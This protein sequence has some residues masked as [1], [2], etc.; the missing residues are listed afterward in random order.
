MDRRDS[1]GGSAPSAASPDP[2]SP[3][4]R[5]GNPHAG[6]PS[7]V[8]AF[9]ERAGPAEVVREHVVAPPTVSLPK[10]GGSV[11]GMGEQFQANPATGSAGLS[12]PLGL[13]PGR[14]GITPQLSLSYDS[15]G[16]NGPFGMGW[17]LSVPAVSR[18]TSRGI[19]RYH[20]GRGRWPDESDTFQLSDSEASGGEDLVPA[21]DDPIVRTVVD[22][23][24]TW[25]VHRYRPRVESGF[26]RIERFSL[27][28]S[29]E[30]YW[31]TIS[32]SNVVRTYGKAASARVVDPND[33][34]RIFEWLLEEERDERGHVVVYEYK[35]EDRAGVG[36]GLSE[37]HRGDNPVAWTYLKRVRYG[38][39]APGST[40]SFRFVLVLD[41]GEHDPDDPGVDDDTATGAP[42]WTLRQDPF[43]THRARFERR[44]YRLCQRVLM[45][46]HFTEL[47][48]D[49][50]PVRS[51]ELTYDE[52]PRATTLSSAL[53]RGWMPNGSGGW[54]TQTLPPLELSYTSAAI[55]ETL[56]F[57]DGLDDLPQ[58]LDTSQ[59]QWVDL[60]GEGLTGLLGQWG[61]AWW[62]QRNEG[63]ATLGPRVRLS[64]RPNVDLGASG[65]RL[66]DLGGDGKLDVV[67]M[68]GPL[69]GYL[70]RDADRNDWK[71]RRPL[72]DLPNIDIE[73]PNV[74]SIDLTGDGL[75]DLLITEDTV[76]P[77]GGAM[78]WY[79]S[80][81]KDGYAEGKRSFV[82]RDLDRGPRVLFSAGN[83]IIFLADMTGDGLADIVRV[84]HNAVDYWPNQGY[85]SF[86]VRVQMQGAP[87]LDRRERFDPKRVRLADI[88]GTGPTDLLYIGP[89]HVR[90]W[91][92]RSGNGFDDAIELSKLKGVSSADD[93]QLADINGD[94]TQAL[95]WS[96]PLFSRR[97]QPLRYLSLMAEGQPYL[98]KAVKNNL[99]RETRLSYT[100]ST[101]F[102][103]ADRK[104]GTPWA[105]RLPFPVQCL[106][107]VEVLDH[108]PGWR[109]TNTY[110]Y[111]HGYF[112]GHEREF[113]G[114]GMVEQ[115]DTESFSD[116]E[117]ASN[118]DLAH[119]AAPVVT[120][121][122]L[123]TGAWPDGSALEDAFAS[124][125]ADLGSGAH[126]PRKNVLPEGL[127]PSQRRDAAR[128]LRGKPLR[129]EVY[130]DDGTADAN[131][132]YSVVAH[133][134][135]VRSLED[136]RKFDLP[137][138][139]PRTSPGITQVVPRESVTWHTERDLTDPRVAHS[140]VL[141]V[142]AYGTVLRQAEVVYPRRGSG[143]DAE[144]SQGKVVV[145]AHTVIDDDTTNDRLHLAVPSTEETWE[146]TG[147]T[148]SEASAPTVASLNT[149]FDGASVIAFHT[150]PSTGDQKRRLSRLE[151]RYW[152]NDLSNTLALGTLG[153]R[154]LVHSKRL[155]A[156]SD[157]LV[158]DRFG[159]KVTGTH[160]TA[161]GYEEETGT[162]IAG[163]YLP[164]GVSTL[165]SS[166]F[167]RPS[168][169]V[170]PFG[171]T[172]TLTYDSHDLFVTEVADPLSNTVVA[173]HDYRVLQPWKVTDP[174]GNRVE[175]AFDAM[176]R[177]TAQATIGKGTSEGDSLS[178]PTQRWTYEP[179]RWYEANGPAR[180]KHE[181]R[182]EH[183]G[184]ADW[185]VT[186]AYSDGSGRVVQLK[187]QAAPG[188]APEIVSGS[189]VWSSADPRWVGSGRT[190]VDNKGRVVKQYEPF[191]SHTEAFEDEDELVQWGV[192]PVY[193]YD[194]IGRMVGT[195]LPDGSW[196][197]VEPGAWDTVTWDECD[198]ID[199]SDTT[200]PGYAHRN[201]PTTA[202]LDVLGRPYQVEQKLDG[203]TTLTTHVA[204]DIQG[205]PATLTDP[206]S[207]AIHIQKGDCLGRG[208]YEDSADA[209]ETWTL[210][211]VGGQPVRQWKSGDLSQRW[212][213]D[214]LRRLV[215]HHA[216][217][218]AGGTERLVQLTIYGEILD[219]SY[220]ADNLR[221]RPWR[222]YDTAGVQTTGSFDFKGNPL[223][224][225]RQVLHH[226]LLESMAGANWSSLVPLPM[227]G[228]NLDVTTLES[229]ASSALSSE[230]FTASQ[231][232]DALGR[233]VTKTS[234]D[235]SVVSHTYDEGA[236]LVAISGDLAY[237]SATTDFVTD[238]E[239]NPRGQRTRVVY[240]NDTATT[241]TYDDNRFWP[242]RILTERTSDSP[243]TKLQDLALSYDPVGNVVGITDS[244]QQ[245]VFFANTQVGPNQDFTYD[246]LYRLVSATGREKDALPQPGPGSPT[247]GGLPAGGAA[248]TVL[249]RYTEEYTYDDAGNLTEMKHIRGG[250]TA[251]RRGY[252]VDT[253]SNRLLKS[254]L[255]GDDPDDP[256][257][258]S[259]AYTWSSR[260]TLVRIPHL[261]AG[262]DNLLPDFRDQVRKAELDSLG[263]VA[264]YLYDADRKRVMKRVRQGQNIFDRIYVGEWEVWRHTTGSGLQQERE[265]LHVMDGDKRLCM[266]ETLTWTGGS[267]VGTPVSRYRF[268]LG[269]HLDSALLEVNDAGEVITYEEY[270]PYG[271]TAWW[272]EK[273]GIQVS[274]KR[275]R[276][277]GME[278][279]EETGLSYHH[280]RYYM[281]WLGRWGS[282]DPAGLVD[283]GNRFGYCRGSP[284]GRVD[285]IGLNSTAQNAE[286][287]KDHDSAATEQS[288]GFPDAAGARILP[289]WAIP[290]DR[291]F[292]WTVGRIDPI[293]QLIGLQ[294]A[295]QSAVLTP[296]QHALAIGER[297]D[298]IQQSPYISMSR[299]E[300]GAPAFTGR[301]EG[302]V[303]DLEAVRASGRR[304]VDQGELA[305]S[306]KSATSLSGEPVH[307]DRIAN[308]EAGQNQPVFVDGQNVGNEREVL[309]AGEAPAS[310]VGRQRIYGAAKRGSQVLGAIGTV[311]TAI[312]LGAA[313]QA[314]YD[315]ESARPIVEELVRQGGAWAGS[316]LGA[317]AGGAF[318]SALA[319]ATAPKL[320][321]TLAVGALEGRMIGAVVGGAIG[322]IAG[323]E[324]A[325]ALILN[326]DIQ[327]RH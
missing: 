294:A 83:E 261:K 233:I 49:P 142:D 124:E 187:A 299:T 94:G 219:S 104:A 102:Y 268:Q 11:Q 87:L 305:A 202:R 178:D 253:A 204:L 64:Q 74:R 101:A 56:A 311:D 1:R 171:E 256:G 86:G 84:R 2:H 192:T 210:L 322:G 249:A 146:L 96:S 88:D 286:P 121:T 7:T 205:F 326:F 252:D 327:A 45:F 21:M 216:T 33:S 182:K 149:A 72:R 237:E 213:Y 222:S 150:A 117:G 123:H 240:G 195:D 280:H 235:G 119:H 282:A 293:P 99:G 26:A 218:G 170:D 169:V 107:K 167:Y 255:P 173:V 36:T 190:V 48:T 90:M 258:F 197:K 6:A 287:T 133:T 265:T 37:K 100:A 110:T 46:H 209:G 55:S 106:S 228:G 242:T 292:R 325:D 236:R 78:W 151:V 43:S 288:E 25:V 59:V 162:G 158:A 39:N 315:T 168:A 166:N 130:A 165:D 42:D 122:W 129:V 220:D 63:N 224:T 296:G 145:T 134:Y 125:Y 9:T 44:C 271:S 320:P 113:R 184:T 275:Y 234:P 298:D 314:S 273:S 304:V 156:F 241:T 132:P 279:D 131:K 232:F 38:N 15:G 225:E 163:W 272:A 105:T 289:S 248:N 32:R 223:S 212:T 27:Q 73:G 181:H 31:R 58:G 316:Y 230:T 221:G 302:Y 244:A 143:H 243:V 217:V 263:N 20:D 196:R 112:D 198:T 8:H 98:L 191:F 254:S 278:R 95:V 193:S 139:G 269:N 91:R 323:E 306:V 300:G 285:S 81:G 23:S 179:Q 274:R 251:W 54:T 18:K 239:Y 62:Y 85:G 3:P 312:K 262:V 66:M 189:V 207:I 92:S 159:T 183:G 284:V 175:G 259:Q 188:D 153:D 317:K 154:A 68:R 12:I 215:Q 140:L 297:V 34:S 65:T 116:F 321:P 144:Q 14:D 313:A 70:E 108:V 152:N 247:L 161:A 5:P 231:T 93:V 28:G 22:G 206:R 135:E 303:V 290:A 52:N 141:E 4:E 318:G 61:G 147:P 120:K 291:A 89:D 57:V 127:P 260:G 24:D 53:H 238:I 226:S 257:T 201:T 270:H 82:S 177:L 246:A 172:T 77:T 194:P 324:A 79:E 214:E 208:A 203:S 245:T 80:R 13:S 76:R 174:N 164:S 16:G 283:G 267:A 319:L 250:T 138:I 199:A 276:Y 97:D 176:G 128:A 103:V 136:P 310:S 309:V 211:D 71:A 67:Q 264:W 30:V 137:G 186:Y 19:P 40:T 41:Y 111:R 75:A 295:D 155:L 115:R 266:V 126:T 51:L 200:N 185:Q 227:S 69:P 301:G 50:V 10:G 17:R 60:D 148:L 35:A 180:V 29:T 281:P 229:T 118:G 307:P 109:F 160:L 157:G 277:T 114:F 308:W 47:G